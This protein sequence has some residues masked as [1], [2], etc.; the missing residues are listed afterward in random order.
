MAREAGR[1]ALQ[2]H[3]A[4]CGTVAG[5]DWNIPPSPLT[6]PTRSRP[7]PRAWGTLRPREGE[8]W[9]KVTEEACA[10]S[11]SARPATESRAQGR[12]PQ[13]APSAR[14]LFPG[15]ERLGDPGL[16]FTGMPSA[17]RGPLLMFTLK[18][19]WGPA[20]AGQ[21]APTTLVLGRLVQS[22]LSAWGPLSRLPPPRQ[23][24]AAL[25]FLWSSSKA[26]GTEGSLRLIAP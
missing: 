4:L 25:N 22:S 13:A 3:T 16:R 7:C 5:M 8:E 15:L 21:R 26:P 20:G 14:V 19:D 2:P 12:G 11:A 23:H 9:P 17:L 10:C 24:Q 18:G 6:T 1:G